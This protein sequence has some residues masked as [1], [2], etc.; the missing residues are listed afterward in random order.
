[1]FGKLIAIVHLIIAIFL[2]FYAFI[3][4]KNRTLDYLYISALV[5]SQ[6]SWIVFNHECPFSYLY[7]KIYYDNYS[8]GDTTTM[9]DFNELNFLSEPNHPSDENKKPTEN[10]FLTKIVNWIFCIAMILSVCI[11]AFRSP[12]IHPSIIIFVCLFLRFFYLFFNNATGYDTRCTGETIFGENYSIFKTIYDSGF[13]KLHS[14]INTGLFITILVF[15]I[16]L[17]YKFQK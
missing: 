2:S 3:I 5:L 9:D 13:D 17:T 10:S 8:C 14:E 12:I 15:W 1:M 11:V 6:L 7:K 4:S 16:Y